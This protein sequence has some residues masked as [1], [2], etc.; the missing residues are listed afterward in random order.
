MSSIPISDLKKIIK[1]F[2]RKIGLFFLAV[3]GLY[4]DSAMLAETFEYNQIL[5][6]IVM[7]VGFYLLYTRSTKRVKELMIYGVVLGFIGEYFFS[8]YLEMYTYRL[9]NVPLYIPFGHAAVYAR[10]FAF[11]KAPV[12]RKHNKK[13]ERFFYGIISLFAL[14]YAYFFNDVFGVIMT[15]GVFALL[16]KRPKDR[17]Y[18]LTMY[19]TVAVLEIGGTAYGAWYWPNT[20]FGVFEFLPSNNP[21][22]GISLFYFLLDIGCFVLYTQ[23]NRIAW[24]R[25]KNIRSIAKRKK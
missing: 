11:S 12:V 6:N 25:V 5:I 7:L 19:I 13:I 23:R 9:G 1:L 20:A 15:L 3:A 17:M 18:F 16:L 14:G 24:S 8:V 21:P 4:L 10:V 2:S 22:S